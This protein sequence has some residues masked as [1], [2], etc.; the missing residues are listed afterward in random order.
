MPRDST[1]AADSRKP[2]PPNLTVKSGDTVYKVVSVYADK[3]DFRKLW[4]S[5]I[6]GRLAAISDCKSA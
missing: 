5:L 3:G 4:E 2:L 1:Q 6:I